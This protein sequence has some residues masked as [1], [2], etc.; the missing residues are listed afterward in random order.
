VAA[1]IETAMY[2]FAV[3]ERGRRFVVS[4]ARSSRRAATALGRPPAGHRRIALLA[5]PAIWL[6]PGS[7]A[8]QAAALTVDS[9]LSNAPTVS[10]G[11]GLGRAHV[12]EEAL[13][14]GDEAG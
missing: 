7:A 1:V 11:S 5:I 10:S 12:V 6:F 14:L 13:R 4:C 9:S 8:R 3:R 2:V